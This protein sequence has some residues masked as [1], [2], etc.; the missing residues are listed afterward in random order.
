MFGNCYS[1]YVRGRGGGTEETAKTTHT[2]TQGDSL[3]RQQCPTSIDICVYLC[4]TGGGTGCHAGIYRQIRIHTYTHTVAAGVP[5]CD[6][7]VDDKFLEGPG[8][9]SAKI[10]GRLRTQ[11]VYIYIYVYLCVCHYIYI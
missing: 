8:K 4:G 7:L 2:R 10:Y 1:G 11:C 9:R 6:P 3:N 5:F